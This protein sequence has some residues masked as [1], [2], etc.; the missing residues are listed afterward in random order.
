MKKTFSILTLV[1][2]LIALL[3][4][5][6]AQAASSYDSNFN[7]NMLI[8]DEAFAD[9]GTF[10]S[11]GGIQNFLEQHDSPLADTSPDF[12][13]KL[14]EPDSTIKKGL[15]DP[16]PNLGRLR[17][18]AELIY[19]ASTSHGLNPQ[20]I[21]VILEKEQSLITGNFSGDALQHRMD[22][23]L[24]FGC[25]DYEGCG[26]IFTGFYRQLFGTF[27]AEGNRWL[28]AAASLMRSFLTEVNGVRVGRGPMVDA[29]NQV[30]GRPLVRTA[31]KGDTIVIDNTLG[32]YKG[33]EAKQT[34]T[35]GNF[36]TAALYRYTPHVFN[37]N[38]NFWH[39]Y[40][41]WFKYPNGT[42]IKLSKDK[43]GQT[44]VI[45][46]GTKRPFSPLVAQQ[47]KIK[48]D[49]IITVS[50]SEFDSYITDKP[51][52][53]LDGTLIK[54]DT[55]PAVYLIE[56]TKKHAISGPVFAQRGY[57]FA[58]VITIPQAEVDTY[59]TGSYVPPT[60]GTLIVGETDGTVYLVDAG[61]KR[62]ITYDVFV[63]RKYSFAK[64]MKLSDAEVKG[65]PS[66]QFVYPPD[67]VAIQ[68]K[69][70]TGI[71][72]FKDNQKRFVSAFV[73]GQRG[74]ANFPTVQLG[75]LEFDSIPTGTPFPPRDGTV[76][77]GDQ[78]TAI[79]LMDSGLKRLLTPA[80]YKRLRSPKP[81]V[82]P[83]AEVDGY[84]A[85][86]LLDK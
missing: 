15:E 2:A 30:F 83:Q 28:G 10:G 24:G 37:G 61:L 42:V 40:Y 68:L 60:D 74:V 18:A 44:Y 17:T 59:D 72:W 19:D 13:V 84:A 85:G 21:L 25:P 76:I 41:T 54:G 79:Y 70:S 4:P 49:N 38:Y 31:R 33:V 64:L 16:Q 80:S 56:D 58:N 29:N 67:S 27:D 45:D 26:D 46:N 12:L 63:A 5:A 43:T 23:A 7:P 81:T 3:P 77:Q 22:R 48:T 52:P 75:Q 14:K 51:M 86:E 71:F 73:Y 47:R 36:A 34:V 50:Q 78:S 20:V 66:G 9:V 65:I 8:T 6:P 57:S 69:G 62:P 11:A 32:G 55:S 1:V 35:L 39:L 53:P 82:L